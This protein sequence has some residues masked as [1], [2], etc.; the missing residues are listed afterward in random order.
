M[1]PV[2]TLTLLRVV[3]FLPE[4]SGRELIKEALDRAVAW[5]DSWLPE[6]IEIIVSRLRDD[7]IEKVHARIEY[8]TDGHVWGECIRLLGPRLSKGAWVRA[9]RYTTKEI[10]DHEARALALSG[11]VKSKAMHD[12][13]TYVLL[14]QPM[15][16]SLGFTRRE[17]ALQVLAD[18]AP[19]LADLVGNSG[20]QKIAFSIVD[21]GEWVP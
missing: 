21:V 6:F 17:V 9:W 10:A 2:R 20:L 16:R 14:W 11:L 19:L 4:T 5:P 1:E 7:E 13:L 15:F 8:C 3:P 12:N 18:V